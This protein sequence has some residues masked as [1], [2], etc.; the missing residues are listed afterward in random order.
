MVEFGKGKTDKPT[1]RRSKTTRGRQPTTD[2]QIRNSEKGGR[3]PFNYGAARRRRRQRRQQ[4]TAAHARLPHDPP[5]VCQHGPGVAR[6]RE[7]A[8]ERRPRR[9]RPVVAVVVVV[10]VV[11]VVVVVVVVL[12]R[13]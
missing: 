2:G 4:A 8:R 1:V 13:Q 6:V 5:R 10:I 3:D 11:V 7:A 12:A 9:R